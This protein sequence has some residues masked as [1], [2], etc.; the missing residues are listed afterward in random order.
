MDDFSLVIGHRIQFAVNMALGD[1]DRFS[2]GDG[3]D[4]L[5]SLFLIMI[6]IDDQVD[7]LL[8]GG[9]DCSLEDSRDR[10]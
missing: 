10:S 6:D 2:S 7:P 3:L 1:V 9:V 5:V 8:E 4:L